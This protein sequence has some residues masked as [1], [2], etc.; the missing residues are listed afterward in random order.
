MWRLFGSYGLQGPSYDQA[1]T[2]EDASM[3]PLDKVEVAARANVDCFKRWAK[4]ME[5]KPVEKAI[6]ILKLTFSIRKGGF[7]EQAA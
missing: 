6:G 4:E 7:S 2:Y 1:A 3:L 5:L